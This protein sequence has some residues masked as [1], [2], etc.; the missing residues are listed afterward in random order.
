MTYVV[1]DLTGIAKH[2]E[3]MASRSRARIVNG[4]ASPLQRKLLQRESVIWDLA[5][6][7]LKDTILEPKIR[8]KEDGKAT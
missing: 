8:E 2:F 3:E 6:S 7:F 4:E 5:A 1:E